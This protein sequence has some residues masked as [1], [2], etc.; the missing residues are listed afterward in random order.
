MRILMTAGALAL[1][2]ASSAAI[3]APVAHADHVLVQAKDAIIL[4]GG[5]GFGSIANTYNQAGLSVGYTDEV[6]RELPYLLGTTHTPTFACC[7]WFGE[8]GTTSASV[9]YLV[10]ASPRIRGITSFH[11]WNEESSGI[12]VFDL[13]Y[14][15][16]PG[17]LDDLVIG[18][19]VPTD[20]LVVD[21]L[22]DSWHFRARPNV[23]WWTL[24]MSGCPQP[25]VGSFPACAIGEVVWNGPRV[26]EP[27]TWAMMLA[28]FGLVGFAIRRKGVAVVS[29]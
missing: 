15:A 21:Y 20:H 4:A 26:P 14:G 23:G 8:S 24:V 25:I 28:G 1:G 6:T 13:W 22:A 3:A 19:G 17:A 11:L 10:A 12:G 5:P 9:T 16:A 2:F 29:A 18:G 7:E 27:A